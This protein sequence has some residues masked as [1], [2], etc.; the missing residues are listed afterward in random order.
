MT[1]EEKWEIE[2]ELLK[3]VIEEEKEEVAD[4]Q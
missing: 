4:K 3:D 1:L 2:E